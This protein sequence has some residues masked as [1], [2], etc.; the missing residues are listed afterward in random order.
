MGMIHEEQGDMNKAL[1]LYMVA[2]H[3]KPSDVSLWQRV[4][5]L[6]KEAGMLKE[7]SYCLMKAVQAAPNDE[8]LLWER[9]LLLEELGESTRVND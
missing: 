1:M 9:A 3:L 7:A 4:T 5:F 2:A 8:D 6:S